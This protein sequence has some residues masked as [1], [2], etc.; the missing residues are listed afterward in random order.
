MP[1]AAAASKKDQKKSTAVAEKTSGP[2]YAV[3]AP[4][5]DL[6]SIATTVEEVP[7]V[8][9]GRP[10]Q[11]AF[12]AQQEVLKKE[13]DGLQSQL[14]STTKVTHTRMLTPFS[15]SAVKEKIASLGKGGP[16]NERRNELKAEL[17]TLRGQQAGQKSSRSKIMEELKGLQEENQKKVYIACIRS[18]DNYSREHRSR[19]SRHPR[20]SSH[21]RLSKTSTTKSSRYFQLIAPC[22]TDS[23]IGSLMAR[24]RAGT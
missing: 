1:S 19:T 6:A 22:T 2:N 24:L 10:D 5:A 17:D 23:H 13:I 15:Q 14:V 11:L 18:P 12:N 7:R 8:T 9:G 20:A 16:A 21:S 4:K 3:T